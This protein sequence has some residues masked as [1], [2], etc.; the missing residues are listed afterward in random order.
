MEARH[1]AATTPFLC[2]GSRTLGHDDLRC[3]VSARRARPIVTARRPI[4]L[5]LD[6]APCPENRR[7]SPPLPGPRPGGRPGARAALLGGSGMRGGF[8][9]LVARYGRQRARAGGYPATGS[10][11]RHILERGQASRG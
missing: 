5:V 3:S 7:R 4:T 11:G 6:L 9:T 1:A 8:R 2:F 10:C